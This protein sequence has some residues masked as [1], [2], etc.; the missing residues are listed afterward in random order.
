MSTTVAIVTPSCAPTEE[1]LRGGLAALEQAGFEVIPGECTYQPR[2][3]TVA[4]DARRA[5]ELEQALLDPAVDAVLCARGGYGVARLLDDLNLA[6]LKHA[7]KRFCG[8]SD[9]TTLHG[10]LRRYAPGVERAYGPMAASSML[11]DGTA[12]C[13][14]LYRY[15]RGEPLG[16]L[17]ETVPADEITVLQSGRVTAPIAG[18]CLCLVVSTLGTPYEIDTRDRILLIEDI[19]E[20]SR[21]VDRYLT[22]LL[23]A[24]KL[25]RV[26]GVIAGRT[27]CLES[28]EGPMA[29][30]H[31]ILARYLEPLG[32]PV[33]LDVPVGHVGDLLT[34][35]LGRQAALDTG[36][37]GRGPSL[38]MLEA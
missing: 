25:H 7:E 36:G 24:G 19:N 4:E 17:L 13:E 18:G 30:Q 15:L 2:P 23:H 33:L 29:T 11:R 31:E 6:R 26:A 38:T 32:V 10:I 3:H 21:R 37:P 22:Q 28:E 34:V 1:D 12:R 35:P 20:E 27:F 5:A 14:L 8:Y 9:I 16:D